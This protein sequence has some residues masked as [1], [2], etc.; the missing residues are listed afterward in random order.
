MSVES[1][2]IADL[3]KSCNDL[4]SYFEQARDSIEQRIKEMMQSFSLS[5]GGEGE[6]SKE[7]TW[8]APDRK[9]YTLII[10]DIPP[11][12]GWTV[13]NDNAGKPVMALYQDAAKQ[14]DAQLELSLDGAVSSC[15]SLFHNEDDY[16]KVYAIATDGGND[17]MLQRPAF[18]ITQ[19]GVKDCPIAAWSAFRVVCLK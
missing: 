1:D 17:T 19:P 3:I 14:K 16:P 11:A 6:K 13:I 10:P 9:G 7:I 8:E 5:R 2:H 4:K 12:N 18:I 15:A